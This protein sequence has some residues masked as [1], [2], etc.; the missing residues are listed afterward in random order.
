MT[1]TR[2][3]QLKYF[4]NFHPDPWGNDPIWRSYFSN[5]LKPRP[6]LPQGE[7]RWNLP[8]VV[9][10]FLTPPCIF[11]EGSFCNGG[12][13]RGITRHKTGPSDRSWTHL[14]GTLHSLKLTFSHLKMDGWNTTF[15]LGRPIFRCYVSFRE[16][17]P[18]F[19]HGCLVKHPFLMY[20]D[21]KSSNWNNYVKIYRC[22]GY[23]VVVILMWV[24]CS[25]TVEI[26][27]SDFPQLAVGCSKA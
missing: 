12:T 23:Q 19:L 14:P 1:I 16:G 17:K 4:W 18:S 27:I 13:V 6:R 8:H 26:R 10:F 15:P 25:D 5:G 7:S 24:S 22:F 21:L 9:F 20:N 11:D 3:W 2:W